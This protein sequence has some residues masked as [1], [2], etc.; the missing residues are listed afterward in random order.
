MFLAY[1]GGYAGF[2]EKAAEVAVEGYP[3]FLLSRP[4]AC[5]DRSF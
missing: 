4:S 5:T 2:A 3:G 1:T